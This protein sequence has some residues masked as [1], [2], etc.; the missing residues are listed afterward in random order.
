MEN[1][2]P[3]FS[4]PEDV[5]AANSRNPSWEIA[6]AQARIIATDDS[7]GQ[8]DETKTLSGTLVGQHNTHVAIT[9][10]ITPATELTGIPCLEDIDCLID[11]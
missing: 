3:S 8:G 11:R 2:F 6:I 5:A 9:I 10:T 1:L 7:M 4:T